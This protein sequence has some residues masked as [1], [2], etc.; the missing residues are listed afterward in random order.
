MLSA[1]HESKKGRSANE[2]RPLYAAGAV[3][4]AHDY[5]QGFIGTAGD[6]LDSSAR[7]VIR[8]PYMSSMKKGQ[9]GKADA[10]YL[11]DYFLANIDTLNPK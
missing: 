4:A 10:A 2:F 3:R 11:R 5:L 9:K 1:W 7:P 6:L 8:E